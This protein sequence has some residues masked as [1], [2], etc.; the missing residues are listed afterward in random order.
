MDPTPI[1]MYVYR[2]WSRGATS[3][4]CCNASGRSQSALPFLLKTKFI[5]STRFYGK[6]HKKCTSL[7]PLARC[8]AIS[9]KTI[10]LRMFQAGYVF[11]NKEIAL[12][13]NKATVMCSFYVARLANITLKKSCKCRRT[14]R[15]QSNT[16]QILACLHWHFH[17]ELSSGQAINLALTRDVSNLSRS[18]SHRRLWNTW[19]SATRKHCLLALP[20]FN[21]RMWPNACY[22]DCQI[23]RKSCFQ[24]HFK[25]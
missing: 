17:P 19:L 15:K 9:N 2:N 16:L 21:T 10:Y 6:C 4:F 24:I 7:T 1:Y 12:V 14:R 8:I 23:E 18:F 20:A 25:K 3:I 13:F 11:T 22:Q 5:H